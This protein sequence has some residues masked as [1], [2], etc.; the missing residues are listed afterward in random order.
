MPPLTRNLCL[1]LWT[2]IVAHAA[3]SDHD[4]IALR[5]STIGS[6]WRVQLQA[7]AVRSSQASTLQ[8]AIQRELDQ[9]EAALSHWREGSAVSRFNASRSTGWQAVPAVVAEAARVAR[10]IADES[11]GALDVTIAPL[12]DLWGF[13]ARSKQ[14]DHPPDES[15]IKAARTLC[16]WRHLDVRTAPEPAL[17]KNLAE[18]RINLSSVA[19]GLAVDHVCTLLRDQGFQDFLVEV[20]GEVVAHGEV[21]KGELWTIGIQEPDAPSGELFTSLPLQDSALATSGVYRQHF[22]SGGHSYPHVIDPASGRP[23]EHH[24]ASVSVLHSRCAMA[25]GYATA[26]LVLGP[27]RGR[28]LA[29]RLG[30]RVVWI[31]HEP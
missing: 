13:G 29:D 8:E 7:G 5:G 24:L 11:G 4:L 15:E 31:A 3:A 19:E 14:R 2:I 26:L 20:G 12:V 28:E 1:G 30:L 27:E 16:G 6:S 17:R 25:D 23:V 22:E 10:Q 21:R 9:M 18:L